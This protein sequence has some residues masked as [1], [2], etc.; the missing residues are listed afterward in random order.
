MVVGLTPI[1]HWSAGDRPDAGRDGDV[2][3][4]STAEALLSE[5]GGKTPTQPGTERQ[6]HQ[7]QQIVLRGAFNPSLW[8]TVSIR[9][10]QTRSSTQRK[11]Q[12]HLDK[13]ARAPERAVLLEGSNQ[14]RYQQ[15]QPRLLLDVH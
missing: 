15:E 10:A 12:N 3:V 13:T 5:T 1:L 6:G 8:L 2:C 4:P 11:R 14:R 9:R 7:G